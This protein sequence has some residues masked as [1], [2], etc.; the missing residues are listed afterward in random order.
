MLL[1]SIA[2]KAYFT[3]PTGASG[4]GRPAIDSLS[5]IEPLDNTQK[6]WKNGGGI[7]VV[8]EAAGGE[9]YHKQR[10]IP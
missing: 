10:S 3:P 1:F 5:L 2:A 7:E 6:S 4:I 9:G 8:I